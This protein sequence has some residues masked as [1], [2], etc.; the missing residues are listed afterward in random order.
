MRPWPLTLTRAVAGLAAAATVG[1]I[2]RSPTARPVVFVTSVFQYPIPRLD[3]GRVAPLPALNRV[4]VASI[5]A[6]SIFSPSVAVLGA[7]G[8]G[9]EAVL[10][11]AFT[12]A[13]F[14]KE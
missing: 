3:A 6:L 12:S 1:D 4:A 9:F 14:A 8:V 10:S 2:G 5:L 7:N 13:S 11:P